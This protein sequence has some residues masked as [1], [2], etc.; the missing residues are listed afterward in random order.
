LVQ[1]VQLRKAND[2]THH[3]PPCHTEGPNPDPVCAPGCTLINIDDV[4]PNAVDLQALARLR[5]CLSCLSDIGI[6]PTLV[7]TRVT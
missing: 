4:I 6:N 7:S 5:G 2:G 1:G 3:T